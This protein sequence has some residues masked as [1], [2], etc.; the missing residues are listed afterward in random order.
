L[1]EREAGGSGTMVLKCSGASF[2]VVTRAELAQAMKG[3]TERGG[4]FAEVAR[5]GDLEPGGEEL[6]V[7][8]GLVGLQRP[9]RLRVES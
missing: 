3:T 6:V 8:G 9:E 2:P 1:V 7:G 4:G 5:G